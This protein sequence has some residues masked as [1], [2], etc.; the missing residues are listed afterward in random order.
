MGRRV[1]VGDVIEVPTSVGLAYAQAIDRKTGM[2]TLL[3]VFDAL[4]ESRPRDLS[5]VVDRP[6]RFECCF[7][8][9]AAVNRDIFEV[10][11]H[12]GV[13]A[14]P[15]KEFKLRGFIDR[16]GTI[17]NW[18]I[19]QGEDHHLIESLSEEQKKLPYEEIIND[20]LL[21]ER[22]EDGWRHETGL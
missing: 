19:V 10:V 22:I 16:D 17:H 15:P 11:G 3:R 14:P 8:L 9:Q 2:G 1:A 7:P 6:T 12:E 18:F 21:I 4:F 5:K 20:T 13:K